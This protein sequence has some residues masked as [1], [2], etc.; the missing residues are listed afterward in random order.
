MQRLG[1]LG[2]PVLCQLLARRSNPFR[3]VRLPA[4]HRG[5]RTPLVVVSDCSH[6]VVQ[7]CV[8]PDRRWCFHTLLA[9]RPVSLH[10]SSIAQASY[11]A[12]AYLV[13]WLAP[14]A[15]VA[16]IATPL[17]LLQLSPRPSVGR[18]RI[19]GANRQQRAAR[20]RLGSSSIAAASTATRTN[21]MLVFR[22]S[23]ERCTRKLYY[24]TRT[25]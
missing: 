23:M 16:T 5:G 17:Q 3:H 24:V 6:V 14:A 9:R 10:P 12:C 11:R 20:Q 21:G 8:V 4:P 2:H 25:L 22:E 7:E 13:Y 15:A 19:R 1:E 18:E